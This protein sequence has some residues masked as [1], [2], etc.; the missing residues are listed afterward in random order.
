MATGVLTF[1]NPLGLQV[2]PAF[3]K[4]AER[5]VVSQVEPGEQ[6]YRRGG[7]ETTCIPLYDLTASV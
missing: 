5:V 7:I 6:G 3:C 1:K 2:V 4:R